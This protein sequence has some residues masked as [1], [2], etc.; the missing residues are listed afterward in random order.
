MP[1]FVLDNFFTLASI[2]NLV[3]KKEFEISIIPNNFLK[4]LINFI[5][6]LIL[7]HKIYIVQKDFIYSP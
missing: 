2:V 5:I 4:H 1:I 6:C 7:R 3:P